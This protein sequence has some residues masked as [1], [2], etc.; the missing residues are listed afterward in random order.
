MAYDDFVGGLMDRCSKL[1]GDRGE[2]IAI[3][4]G[5]KGLAYSLVD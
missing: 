3:A 1:G 2:A 4:V 5:I